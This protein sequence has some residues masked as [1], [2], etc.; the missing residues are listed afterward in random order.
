[1]INLLV[2]V[3]WGL[4][5]GS[6]PGGHHRVDPISAGGSHHVGPHSWAMAG[7]WMECSYARHEPV[8]MMSSGRGVGVWNE[9]TK[10]EGLRLLHSSPAQDLS[11]LWP[12]GLNAHLAA[13]VVPATPPAKRPRPRAGPP[14]IRSSHKCSSLLGHKT[15]GGA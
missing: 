14:G 15:L 11:C 9:Q 2:A 5:F 8:T 7:R 4:G 1:V 3:F 13:I 12:Q 10:D 6:S